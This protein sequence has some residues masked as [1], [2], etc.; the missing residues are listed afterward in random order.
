MFA[1]MHN[2]RIAQLPLGQMSHEFGAHGTGIQDPLLDRNFGVL[3]G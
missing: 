2:G 3:Q 1:D